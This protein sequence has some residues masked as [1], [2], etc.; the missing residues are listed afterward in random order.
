MAGPNE[1]LVRING[2]VY[3]WANVT[4]KI[5]GRPFEGIQSLSYYDKRERMKVAGNNGGG[6]PLGMTDGLYNA[7]DG[8]LEAIRETAEDIRS[9]VALLGLSTSFGDGRFII[10]V[11]VSKLG[12]LAINDSIIGCRI[13]GAGANHENSAEASKVKIPFVCERIVHNGL[14]L[15]TPKVF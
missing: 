10:T 3:S 6:P 15:H 9:Y 13:T 7:E 12:K 8:E 4:I 14:T 5:A 1:Q 2:H 11:S